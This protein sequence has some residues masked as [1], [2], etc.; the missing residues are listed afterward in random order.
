MSAAPD[1]AQPLSGWRA[2]LVA[3]VE[4]APRLVSVV[5]HVL[6]PP[7]QALVG[8]CLHGSVQAPLVV[9][10]AEPE[11]LGRYMALS[12]LSWQLGFTLGPAAGGFALAG[13]PYGTWFA[14]AAV[15]VA[16][17]GAAL[18][19]ERRLPAKARRTPLAVSA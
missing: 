8:E 18:V 6:W 14:A 7:R 9:D 12:A 3:E 4:G 11:L 13:S 15:C 19:L 5:Y 1:Y 2:W 17:G 16:A 10:L